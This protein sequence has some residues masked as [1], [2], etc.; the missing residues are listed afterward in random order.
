MKK[1]HKKIFLPI[2]QIKKNKIGTFVVIHRRTNKTSQ[3]FDLTLIKWFKRHTVSEWPQSTFWSR[4]YNMVITT[5]ESESEFVLTLKNLQLEN[6][7]KSVPY[8][9]YSEST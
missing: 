5:D 3:Q 2:F 6:R 9:I 4:Q 1:N 7:R 8:L